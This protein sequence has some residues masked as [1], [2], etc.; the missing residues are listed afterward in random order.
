MALEAAYAFDDVGS[1]TVLDLSGN[2]RHIELTANAAQVTSGGLLDEGALGKTNTGTVVLPPALLAASETDD[3]GFM[4]DVLGLRSVWWLRWDSESL[5][6][7]VWGTLSLDAATI[8]TRARTQANG[9]PTPNNSTTGSLSASVRHNVAQTYVR[10]TGVLTRYFDGVKIGTQAFTP[11]TALYVGADQLDMA[12]WSSTGPSIDNL[13]IFSHA[14]SDAEIAALAG[15]PVEPEA[16]DET[17][18]LAGTVPMATMDAD[19]TVT[20]SGALVGSVPVATF[21]AALTATAPATLA[22]LSPVAVLDADATVTALAALTSSLPLALL[23]ADAVA[24]AAGDLQMSVPMATMDLTVSVGEPATATLGGVL[25][26]ARVRLK[27]TEDNMALAATSPVLCS[28]WASAEDLTADQLGRMLALGF[29]SDQ[30]NAQLMRASEI[31]WSFSGRQ[32]LGLGCEEDAVLRSTEP[33][34]GT[35]TWPYDKSWGT[36][37]CWSYATWS[38]NVPR[39]LVPVGFGHSQAPTSVQLP[40]RPVTAIV[41]V[42]VGGDSFPD[43]VLQPSGWLQ[44][45]DGQPWNVCGGD[46]QVTYQFGDPPPAG[47]R[48]AAIELGLEMLLDRAGEQECRLPPNAVSVTRQGITMELL[49]TDRPQFT[50]GLPLVD[51]WL[52]AV[53]PY[54]SPQSSQVWSPDVPRLA[55][56]GEVREV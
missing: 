42:T 15:T 10:S 24:T 50:T 47:G 18:T 26:M 31:L 6:T 2:G 20:A 44:R 27:I 23:D 41:A 14:P 54:R 37:G 11:G 7:G 22:G 8:I 32:W 21:S 43:W 52:E 19:G 46:T 16:D 56:L 29:T 34:P 4:L 38:G 13:R 48:D 33:V 36:C 49:S 40:R 51:M 12:E 55:R 28:A 53:N 9:S 1:G 5:D 17:A 3:R 39:G 45:T 30:I 35:G 25:P